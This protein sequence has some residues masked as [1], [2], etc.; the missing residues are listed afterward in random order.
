MHGWGDSEIPAFALALFLVVLVSL[1]LAAQVTARSKRKQQQQQQQQRRSNNNN[2]NH[3]HHHQRSLVIESGGSEGLSASS[4]NNPGAQ[5]KIE[6]RSMLA[7]SSKIC[8]I[9]ENTTSRRC[10]RCKSVRYW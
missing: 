9:C 2:N 6:R 3:H 1:G 7:T 8:A 5:S 4:S 10:S